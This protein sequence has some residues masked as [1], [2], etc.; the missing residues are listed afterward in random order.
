[1]NMQDE[2]LRKLTFS[3][4]EGL[5]PLP[6]ALQAE[7]LST[8]FRNCVWKVVDEK[9][10]ACTYL[11]VVYLQFV[12]SPDGNYWGALR[13]SYH[14]D[15]LEEPHDT[16]GDECDVRAVRSW[17]RKLILDAPAYDE[18]L[19][20][21][22]HMFRVPGMPNDLASAIEK[23]FDHA[24]YFIDRSGAPTCIVSATSEEMKKATVKALAN[25]NQSE[26]GGAKHHLRESAQALNAKN[27]AGSIRESIH[28]VESAARQIDPGNSKSM[29]DALQS[30]TQRNMSIHPAL[31]SA[32][33]MLYG[34]T[35]DEQGIR[36]P[37]I[38]VDPDKIGSDEA[39]FMYA[40]CVS[41]VDYLIAKKP[42]LNK[43]V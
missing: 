15:I 12:D 1:M 38:D 5:A 40:A 19:T 14:L 21:I 13:K 41:F 17:L 11:N 34:Y 30:L 22:E 43:D 31:K 16:I 23:C 2:N 26:L 37:M 35:S 32:F 29:R 18:T 7:D 8:K 4:R 9:F 10:A 36:H 33:N 39:I 27:F 20:L 3:Q 24:L 6:E 25:I 28:A 42:Q